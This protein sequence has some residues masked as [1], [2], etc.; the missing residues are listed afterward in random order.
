[1]LESIS[2]M[3][4]QFKLVL[5]SASPRRKEL[6]TLMGLPFETRPGSFVEPKKGNQSTQNYVLSLAM[7]KAEHVLANPGEVIL[8][9]DTIVDFE[10]EL[11]GKPADDQEAQETLNKLR[12]KP[13]T[14]YTALNVHDVSRDITLQSICKT[15]VYMRDWTAEEQDA[16]IYICSYR[17]KAGGYAIQDPDFHPVERIEGCYANVMGLP[18]CHLYRLFDQL[19]LPLPSDLPEACQKETG[20]MCTYFPTILDNT[21]FSRAIG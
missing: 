10:G 11:L 9:A 8:S 21:A 4:K 2:T 12:A 6:L 20:T 3:K 5:A 14:V 17:D 15:T 7:S 16:Y 13:H 1:M 18:L 19:G